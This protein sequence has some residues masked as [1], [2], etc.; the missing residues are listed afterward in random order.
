MP[1]DR[2]RF[3]IG[4]T[5]GLATIL[6]LTKGDKVKTTF[7]GM[8]LHGKDCLLQWFLPFGLINVL[9]KFQRIMD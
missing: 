4:W 6:P 7:W 3:S 5:Q 2:L 9:V 1:L 8:D